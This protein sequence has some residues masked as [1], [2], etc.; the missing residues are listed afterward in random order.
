MADIGEVF[1]HFL[2][3][4]VG[5]N[6]RKLAQRVKTDW[7]KDEESAEKTLKIWDHLVEGAKSAK[8]GK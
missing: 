3:S 1:D 4:L 2:G 7:G 5:E 6:Q 8:G